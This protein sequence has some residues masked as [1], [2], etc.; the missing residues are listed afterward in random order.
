MQVALECRFC[1][2]RS[3][4]SSS[5]LGRITYRSSASSSGYGGQWRTGIDPKGLLGISFLPCSF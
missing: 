5:S 1:S 2:L 4:S 3:R